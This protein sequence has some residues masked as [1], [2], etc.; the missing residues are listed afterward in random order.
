MGDDRH[1]RAHD[2]SDLSLVSSLV[3][4][5]QGL[6]SVWSFHC[7]LVV[8]TYLN[9]S[10]KEVLS[11]CHR[12]KHFARYFS[13]VKQQFLFRPEEPLHCAMPK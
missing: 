5:E 7:C 6:S 10:F 2:Q 3:V 13:R 4:V 9:V 11:V 8:L 12:A 1:Q